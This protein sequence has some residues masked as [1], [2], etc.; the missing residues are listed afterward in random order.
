MAVALPLAGSVALGAFSATSYA[1]GEFFSGFIGFARNTDH[2][3]LA[4]VGG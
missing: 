3:T 2:Q 4:I 1:E